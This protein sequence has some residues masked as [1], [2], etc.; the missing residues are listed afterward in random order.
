MNKRYFI[1]SLL[2]SITAF[3]L[4]CTAQPITAA[5]PARTATAAAAPATATKNADSDPLA[6]NRL[7]KPSNKRNLPPPEDG[8]H[9]PSNDGTHA[10]LAPLSVFPSLPNA[11]TGNRVD[12]VQ[13]LDAGTIKPRADRADPVEEMI[14]MDMNVVREVKGSM[15]NVVYPHKQHTE[16]L[17]CSNCHPGIFIPLKGANAMSMAAIMLGDKCGVCHGKVAFSISECRKCHSQNKEFNPTP[18]VK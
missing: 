12:W 14:V 13:A 9:D 17:D 4:A 8:I 11:N 3:H 7:H 18:V 10:L 2:I 1:V 16:W 15:P 6:F 5:T